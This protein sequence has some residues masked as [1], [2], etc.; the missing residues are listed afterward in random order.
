[1]EFVQTTIDRQFQ[2]LAAATGKEKMLFYKEQKF[3]WVEI[4]DIAD[5]LAAELVRAGMEPGSRIAIWCSNS[6]M[7]LCALYAITRIGCIFVP[8]NSSFKAWEMNRLI[9]ETNLQGMFFDDATMENLENVQGMRF[10]KYIGEQIMEKYQDA[11]HPNK[12]MMQEIRDRS[13]RV[14]TMDD[15]GILFTSGS[16]GGS[17]GVVLSHYQLLNVAK[18]ACEAMRWNNQDIICLSLPIFHSFGL[19]T[20]VLAAL[21]HKGKV[22]INESFKSTSVMACVQKYRCT[23]LNG[24][25]TMFLS[26]LHNPERHKYDLSS[27]YSGIITGSGVY[28]KDF[29]VISRELAIPHLMQSYGQTEASPSITFS[30][31]EEP[32]DKSARSVGVAIPGMELRIWNTAENRE[33]DTGCNGEIEIKG[34]NVMRGYYN[35]P[36]ETAKVLKE[37]GWL[38]TGDMG[39]VDEEGQL[40]G[41]GRIK[42]MIIRGGENIC[43]MEIEEVL[44]NM[45]HIYQAMVFGV[46]AAVIQE[47]IVACVETDKKVDIDRMRHC[48]RHYLANYKVPKHIFVYDKFPENANGKVDM[49]R[50]KQESEEKIRTLKNTGA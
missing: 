35:K 29:K 50:L 38:R 25:P 42:E 5:K 14:E 20:G 31:Y 18:C 39:Y 47:D 24:V 21:F 32:T 22:C 11:C 45:A 12:E 43:P 2:Q 4:N 44:M 36:E 16:T 37:D 28:E 40:H 27:L 41:I 30:L 13:S 48:M 26:I 7:Y 34:F 1:M 6:P 3:S 46:K 8:V 19:S 9:E 15:A 10:V 23:V 17:K 49:K 33:A